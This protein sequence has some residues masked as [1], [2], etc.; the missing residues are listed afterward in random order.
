MRLLQSLRRHLRV[1]NASPA[2]ASSG[3]LEGI[4]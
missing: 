3:C 1:V 4:Q 2:V